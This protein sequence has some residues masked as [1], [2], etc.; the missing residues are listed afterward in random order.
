MTAVRRYFYDFEFLENGRTIDPIS[1]GVAC[2]DGRDFYAVFEEI[3]RTPLYERVCAHTWLMANVIPHL[4]LS[5]APGS[6][7]GRGYRL[8]VGPGPG[9]PVGGA[10]GF[11]LDINDLT[12]KPRH[13]IRKEL[14]AFLLDGHT[15]G[16]RDIE[17][18]AY[19]AAYDHVALAQLLG[20][21]M[22]DLPAGIPWWTHDLQ[23]ELDRRGIEDPDQLCPHDGAEH[24]ALVDARWNMAVWQ[25]IR[26]LDNG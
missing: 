24:N 12:I 20:G 16:V 14:L 21:P 7:Q 2:D 15:E 19:Y 13:I 10:P 1:I 3:A 11:H 18:W 9:Y 17:L 6:F 4:P 25:A 22:A 8:G 26:N 23:Q 5:T